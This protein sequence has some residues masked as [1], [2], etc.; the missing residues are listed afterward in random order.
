M[1]MPFLPVVEKYSHL[2][3][4]ITWCW[5][6]LSPISLFPL[7]VIKPQVQEPEKPRLFKENNYQVYLNGY[8]SGKRWK[9]KIKML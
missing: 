2:Y 6:T 9:L 5:Y 7:P 3:F 1:H 4:L 8:S